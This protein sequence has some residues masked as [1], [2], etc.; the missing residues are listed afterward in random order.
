MNSHERVMAALR[1]ERPDKVPIW[2]PSYQRA[3]AERWRKDLGLSEEAH[4]LTHYRHDT[5]ILIGD[6]SYFPSQKKV[7]RQDGK[8]TVANN[9]WGCVVRTLGDGYFQHA[10][11]RALDKPGDLAKL[12]FEPALAPL[13]FQGL[14]A[15]VEAAR[16]GGKCAFAKIGG[17]YNRSHHLRAEEL[18]LEDMALD[19]VFCDELFDRVAHHFEA[20]ALE[21]LKRTETWET[22]LFVYDDCCS[23][24]GPMFSPGMFERYFLPRYQALIAR[25]RAAGC[26]HFFFHSDGNLRPI[27]DLLIEAGFE[28]FNPL[29]PRCGPGLVELREKYGRK[30]IPFGGICNTQ[31]LPGGNRREIEAHLRPLV[32]LAREGGV[33]LGMASVPEE[34]PPAAYD[35]AMCLIDELF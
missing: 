35:D 16:C 7:L 10:L 19:E 6:E 3:F 34:M 12:E 28:G 27:L 9:G 14:D 8:E 1:F 13:R 29:E 15:Q 4:P 21:T 18:L 11:S 25:C 2:Q 17:I 32:E 20:M 5:A 31:I 30:L 26:R 22:G 24:K 33:I 23:S